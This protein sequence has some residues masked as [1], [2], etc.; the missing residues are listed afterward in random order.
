MN[1]IRNIFGLDLSIE[2]LK[3]IESPSLEIKPDR[4]ES[5]N[6]IESSAIIQL[7]I[8]FVHSELL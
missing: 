4:S 1:G 7:G 8:S 2:K 6:M 5:G 3:L